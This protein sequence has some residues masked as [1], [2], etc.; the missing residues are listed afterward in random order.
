M[1][2]EQEKWAAVLHC[3][4]AY[5]GKFFYGVKTT[6]IFCR[7]SCK[8][9]TPRLENIEFFS[10]PDDACAC[11]LRPCKRCR[12]DLLEYQPT[13]ELVFKA[14]EV[15]ES[16]FDDRDKLD[17]EIKKLAVSQNHMIRLFHQHFETTPAEY[18]T[19]LRI[20]KA[21]TYLATT[22]QNVLNIAF[23]AGFGSLSSFH[24]C[25]RKKFGMTPGEYR[26]RFT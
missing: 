6:G 23:L 8:S 18:V 25:F 15:F 10:N 4:P 5:D 1:L 14:K 3:D 19:D 24:V 21:A 16:Y 22:H 13:T 12:P 9:K 11:G 26:R 7:P 20:N 2:S 17:S